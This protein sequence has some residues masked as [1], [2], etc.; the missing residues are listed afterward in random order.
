VAVVQRGNHLDAA[1]GSLDR[2]GVVQEIR[3]VHA[4]ESYGHTMLGVTPDNRALAA[5]WKSGQAEQILLFEFP[6][7]K[8]NPVT[9][10]FRVSLPDG[11]FIRDIALSPKGS[12]LGWVL[13]SFGTSRDE[14]WVSRVDG[15]NFRK[16]EEVSYAPVGPMGDENHPKFLTWTPDG[17]NLSFM[18]KNVVCLLPAR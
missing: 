1:I 17:K 2:P 9:R 6:I 7:K 8:P 3:H 15:T 5:I 11:K 10:S 4:I 13:F 16:L 18:Y 12:S 14:L